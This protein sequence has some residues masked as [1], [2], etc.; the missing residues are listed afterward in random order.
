MRK[1]LLTLLIFCLITNSSF[2]QIITTP[3][4]E[5]SDPFY[6]GT[7]G[8]SISTVNGPNVLFAMVKAQ[9][10]ISG[11][12]GISK[13]NADG[14]IK[15]QTILTEGGSSNTPSSS[16][17][18]CQDGGILI[19]NPVDS[20]IRKY[21]TNLNFSWQQSISYSLINATATLANGFYVYAK[22]F[23]NNKNII[24]IKKIKADGSIEWSIDISSFT[25]NITDIQT[26]SDDG[27]I[28]GTNNGLRKYSSTGQLLWNSLSIV[29][30]TKFVPLDATTMYIQVQN[31]SL[32]NILGILQ[33]NT[34]NGSTIWTK[35]F[36]SETIF[37]FAITTDKGC[38]IITNTGLYKFKTNGEQEWKNTQYISSNIAATGDGGIVIVNNN[39]LIKIS[40][41]NIF[42]WTKTFN[43]TFNIS[44]VNSY[45]NGLYVIAQRKSYSDISKP[46]HFI[47]KIASP[48]NPCKTNS[49][50]EGNNTTVC[51]AGNLVL[52]HKIGNTNISMNPP[53]IDFNY[54]WNKNN[55]LI[56]SATNSNYTAQS[57]GKYN[58]TFKQGTCQSNSRIVEFT[59]IDAPNI[60]ADKTPICQG[61]SVNL[62]STGCVGTVIWSNN[63]RGSI[64]K[65]APQV[66]SNYNALCEA[67][68]INN[69]KTETCQ[70]NTSNVVRITVQPFS[71]LK[72]DD[73]NG[74]KEFCEA[75]ST[76]LQPAISGGILPLKFR[77]LKNNA[78]IS[79]NQNLTINEEA[80]YQ[81]FISDNIGCNISSDIINIKKISNPLT[82]NITAQSST[83]ICVG[84]NV[85]ILADAKEVNY[86]WFKNNNLIKDAISQSYRAETAGSYKL[87]VAN[88]N[89]C[90]KLS[91]K[92]II[93]TEII[94]PKPFIRQSNDSL[95]SSYPN[96]NKW[97]LNGT[98]IS[99]NTQKIK[100]ITIG[101]YQ[102]KGV[103]KGCE[104][105]VSQ[106][107]MPI[108]LANEES[109]PLI[110][111]FP[112]PTSGNLSIISPY[113]VNYKIFDTVGKLVKNDDNLHSKFHI[114]ISE[115]SE[116]NYSLILTG[117][118]SNRFFARISV[119]K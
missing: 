87:Q 118:K 79:Q 84:G 98:Q 54:Q 111:I 102:V 77:W 95:I 71:N 53:Y 31:A 27:V 72:I 4:V 20:W 76:L 108:I 28:V 13:F 39:Q 44:I 86:Q 23:V 6:G 106:I 57:T 33:I 103:F 34:Q 2:S 8:G 105:E 3:A 88:A 38:A 48:D 64:I 89:G 40:I 37:D 35:N 85:I 43:T 47:F 12:V 65:V 114:D 62:T 100:F 45:D 110:N 93:V 119:R 36:N 96:Q 117:K 80:G 55:T 5:W 107:F 109:F 29:N 15:T 1:I 90:T 10:S 16:Q 46:L 9:N 75:T 24:E 14:Q 56:P 91:E 113:P 32:N 83:E 97:F 22:S 74:K 60:Q 58:L 67:N 82:P 59:I 52:S 116:G 112:I 17:Y 115:L 81:L 99:D 70:T 30:A 69:G 104:S 68:I 26:T 21:D 92:E 50:I 41:N 51:N 11:T 66:S 19:Y 78:E 61:N 101:N 7:R 18:A 42:N 49:D 94:I 63:E 73:I 25:T